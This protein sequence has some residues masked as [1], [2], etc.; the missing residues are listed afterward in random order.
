[1][2]TKIKPGPRMLLVYKRSP[3]V[4]IKG[5]PQALTEDQGFR[6]NHRNHYASLHMVES[7]LK[8]FKVSFHK[9]ARSRSINYKP[10]DLVITIGGDGTFLEAARKLSKDQLILGVNSDPSWSVGQFCACDAAGFKRTLLRILDGRARCLKVH[11][12][13][14]QLA[15]RKV[16]EGLNDFLICHSNPAAMSRYEI[17]VG[18]IHE[19]HRSSGVWFSSAAG[20]TGAILS[21]GGKR[22]P[23]ISRQLQYRSRELYFTKKWRYR[24]KGGFVGPKKNL[25]VISHMP[26]GQIFVDGAHIRLPFGYGAKAIISSSPNYIQLIHA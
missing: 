10:Y 17:R 4:S 7:V 22:I 1:M 26:H 25:S 5:L 11:K 24:L 20:S 23:L 18:S 6:R 9:R 12:L 8:D 3:L 14:I 15:E 16:V 2:V 21:A 19:E 13:R